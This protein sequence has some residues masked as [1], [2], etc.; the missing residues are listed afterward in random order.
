MR[1]KRELFSAIGR[2]LDIPSEA[3][4]CGFG[5]TLSGQSSMTVRGCRRILTYGREQIRLSLGKTVLAVGGE[6]LL[7]TAFELG[8]V[9]VEGRILTVTFEGGDKDD[10][11]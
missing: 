4:P 10:A 11:T 9:T 1:S 5:L 6:Q 2:R 7:C 3:L 8:C